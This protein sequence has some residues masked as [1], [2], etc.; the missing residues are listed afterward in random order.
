MTRHSVLRGVRGVVLVAGLAITTVGFLM[1]AAGASA[2]EPHGGAHYLG[3]EG[4]ETWALPARSSADLRVSPS[5]SKFT[6]ASYVQIGNSCGFDRYLWLG[7]TRIHDG[8]FAKTEREGPFRA[9]LRG[10]FVTRGYA[11]FR[12]SDTRPLRG[13]APAPNGGLRKGALYENGEPP[14]TA[15]RSQAAKTDLEN[16]D[17]RIFEQLRYGAGNAYFVPIEYACL[18]SVNKRVQL[19]GPSE[20]ELQV[21]PR[22]VAPYAAFALQVGCDGLR[23][24]C[25][26][27]GTNLARVRVRDLRDGRLVSDL[28]AMMPH[29]VVADSNPLILGTEHV[30]DL[31]LKSNR[32]IAWVV[33]DTSSGNHQVVAVDAHG[34]RVL[35]SG[36]GLGL[37]SLTLHGSTLTWVNAGV[38]H[39][40]TLD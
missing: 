13:C 1:A 17:G 16:N 28:P 34:R 7:G 2:A 40:A 31:E 26:P 33:L 24:G 10:H 8:R 19:V 22:L 12:Y 9:R 30:T 4:I 15:C 20:Q 3:F 6:G 18:F 35:D 37:E 39:S 36:A 14:F 23:D 11:T 32:S 29:P 38:T 21:P 27:G 5:G 25:L